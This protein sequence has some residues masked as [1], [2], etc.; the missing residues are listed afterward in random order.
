MVVRFRAALIVG[1]LV[2]TS[3]TGAPTAGAAQT[4]TAC[5]LLTGA[6]AS[7]ILGGH[8]F[9]GR[10]RTNQTCFYSAIRSKITAPSSVLLLQLNSKPKALANFRG[11]LKWT[12]PKVRVGVRPPRSPSTFVR[13]KAFHLDGVAGFYNAPS[14]APSSGP[15]GLPKMTVE[16]MALRDHTV[17]SVMVTQATTPIAA[18]QQGMTDVLHHLDG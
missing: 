18:A 6:Q 3:F 12:N 2:A 9:V 4:E 1:C 11:I 14:T 15:T 5:R 10:Q 7:E 17:V 8:A 13:P 16:F